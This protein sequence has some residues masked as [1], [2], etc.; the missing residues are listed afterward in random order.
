MFEGKKEGWKEERKEGWKEEG[1]CK[2][3]KE[4]GEGKKGKKDLRKNIQ[5][6]RK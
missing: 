5:D 1:M 4:G 3:R 6:G 2:G